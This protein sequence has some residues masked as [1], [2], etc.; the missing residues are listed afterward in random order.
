MIFDSHVHLCEKRLLKGVCG[1]HSELF[2]YSN[3]RENPWKSYRRV[4]AKNGV[5]K[6]IVMP[7][8]F[9]E[10]SATAADEYVCQ[11]AACNPDLMMAIALI[12][13]NV[14]HLNLLRTNIVGAKEHFY[15][16]A[17]QPAKAY[18]AA[19]DFLQQ[20]D[21]V[22]LIHPAMKERVTRVTEIKKNFPR[23]KVILAH[24]GRKWPYTGDEVVDVARKLER[25]DSL[26]FDTSCIRNPNAITRLVEVV[27]CERVLFGSDFP[28]FQSEDEDTYGQEIA[29]VADARLSD[30]HRHHIFQQTFRNLFLR[31]AWVRRVCRQ[32]KDSLLNIIQ[33]I[34]ADERRFLAID[35][36][37]DIVIDAVRNERHILLLETGD[38]IV[39]FAR[40]SGRAGNGAVVEEIYV[41]PAH[42]GKGYAKRLLATFAAMFDW[43][44]MKTYSDNKNICNLAKRAGFVIDK[45]TP[46]GSLLTWK[47]SRG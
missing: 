45:R 20:N 2:G 46:K 4:A 17:G 47:W 24:S 36:K 27:G 41:K 9:K 22:L 11:A 19:Y 31:D 28:Y 21:L 10:L 32:D 15:L 26:F 18:F 1:T 42:R 23:L 34:P 43:M 16:T 39:G 14:S 6:A 29:A 35:K 3:A 44:E 33:D 37:R 30:E 7:L 8:P 5:F 12:T 40:E 13:P 25:F 38:E